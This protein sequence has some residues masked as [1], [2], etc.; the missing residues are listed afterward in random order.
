MQE[1]CLKVITL[2]L[3]LNV[4][5]LMHFSPSLT[6]LMPP[7]STSLS[8]SF[9]RPHELWCASLAWCFSNTSSPQNQLEGLLKHEFPSPTSRDFDSVGLGWGLIISISSKLPGDDVD[10]SRPRATS[11]VSLVL[12]RKF[13]LN[14]QPA[15]TLLHSLSLTTISRE[16]YE[17]G[18]RL[19]NCYPIFALYPWKWTSIAPWLQPDMDGQEETPRGHAAVDLCT[20]WDLL[21]SPQ[22]RL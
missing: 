12:E 7:Y 20:C 19:G 2:I 4:N 5:G 3:C 1:T 18:C 16:A 14:L 17:A 22:T 8:S 15:E 11:W 21:L 9:W 13:Q 10:A 6:P